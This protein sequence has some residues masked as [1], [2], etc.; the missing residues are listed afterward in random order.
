MSLKKFHIFFI[1]T[2]MGLMVFI[3]A[4]TIHQRNL[5][6]AWVGL[7]FSA[8]VGFILGLFYANWFRRKY[9]NL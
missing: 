8:A 6:K 7:G 9:K 2:S 4:W 3:G 1:T 5:G